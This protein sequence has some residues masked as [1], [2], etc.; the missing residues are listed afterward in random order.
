[1]RRTCMRW[2]GSSNWGSPPHQCRRNAGR[3]PK[4]SCS[5]CSLQTPSS[6]QVQR[7]SSI[8]VG[9]RPQPKPPS[10]RRLPKSDSNKCLSAGVKGV[11]SAAAELPRP[12][13]SSG[14]CA[15]LLKRTTT[16][17]NHPAALLT[18]PALKLTLPRNESPHVR[19]KRFVRSQSLG[20]RMN[21]AA[22]APSPQRGPRG[23]GGKVAL[24]SPRRSAMRSD[25][26]GNARGG[27]PPQPRNS[28]RPR[29][30]GCG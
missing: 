8:A 23:R 6:G 3:T 26:R 18:Q 27:K 13:N 20:R 24:H 22:P 5:A 21:S 30:S 4:C 28:V 29:R 12:R 15:D 16:T 10:S 1:M 2:C 19:R 9:S 11:G 7:L 14:R 17:S 25:V